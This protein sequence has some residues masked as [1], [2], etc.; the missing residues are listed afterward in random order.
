MSLAVV[1]STL[2]VAVTL[3][4]I[5]TLALR[6][7]VRA[8]RLLMLKFETATSRA[9]DAW[10]AFWARDPF[11]AA[12]QKRTGPAFAT[13]DIPGGNRIA[14]HFAPE[15]F[16]SHT[17]VLGATGTGKSSL[18]EAFALHHLREQQPF[19]LIDLHGDKGAWKLVEA[20]A[21]RVQEVKFDLAYP[22]DINTPEDFERL[23]T[24]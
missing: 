12:Q 17:L 24:T 9:R 5:I 3:A 18:L 1:A 15:D 20:N 23:V 19:A 13:Y 11:I 7:V 8:P 2:A 4:G 14:V 6:A 16:R 10:T 22:D 21:A